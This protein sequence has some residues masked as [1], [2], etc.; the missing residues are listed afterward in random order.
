MDNEVCEELER[1]LRVQ[2]H[3]F[4]NHLQVIHTLI[5]MGRTEKALKYIEELAPNPDLIAEPL[6]EH[7]K[8]KSCQR[9]V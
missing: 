6:R 2:R 1:L 5:Q 4:M 3:D 8:Q 7:Q 9:S